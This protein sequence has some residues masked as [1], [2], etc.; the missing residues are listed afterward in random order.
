MYGIEVLG[1]C[2][3]KL[4]KQI[5]PGRNVMLLTTFPAPV[6]SR[7]KLDL[8]ERATTGKIKRKSMQTAT[9]KLFPRESHA[10]AKVS[11][12]AR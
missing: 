11:L 12:L 5:C 6:L 7:F 3:T 2:N 4:E 1:L 8:K 10:T 9:A